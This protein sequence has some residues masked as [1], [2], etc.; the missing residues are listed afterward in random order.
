M[1]VK[2]NIL[3]IEPDKKSMTKIQD[4]FNI[5]KISAS[6]TSDTDKAVSFIKKKGPRHLI[7][8]A[9]RV[10]R[11]NLGEIMQESGETSGMISIHLF[12]DTPSQ[13]ERSL[14]GLIREVKGVPDVKDYPA[15]SI[16]DVIRDLGISQETIARILGTSARSVSRWI[17]EGVTPSKVYQERLNMLMAIHHKLLSLIKKE[18]IPKYLQSYNDSL[19]GKRPIDLLLNQEYD[20]ILADLSAMEEGVFT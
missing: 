10:N 9:K 12:K 18:A 1:D 20:K 8:D 13:I 3:V 16:S 15:P 17:I 4:L 6:Y 5:A 2:T 14:E 19:D 11:K 7:V